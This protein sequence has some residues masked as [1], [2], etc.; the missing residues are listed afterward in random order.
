MPSL[1]CVASWVVPALVV[2]FGSGCHP[3]PV[4][5]LDDHS[6]QRRPIFYPVVIATVLLT[7][8]GMI[9]GYLLSERRDRKSAAPAPTTASTSS[10]PDSFSE[11]APPLLPTQGSCPEQT[12]DMAHRNGAT[13]ELQQVFQVVTTRNT[14]IW[15]CQDDGGRLF[16]HANRGGTTAKWEEGVTALFLTGVTAHDDGSFEVT[17]PQDGNTFSV[18]RKRL[19]ITKPDGSQQEQKVIGA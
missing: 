3:V 19:L 13:G 5:S 2:R 9:G 12:Q 17:A 8:I 1:L 11:S 7:I 16:Y 15:I 4:A 10:F 6:Q 18:N 14:W